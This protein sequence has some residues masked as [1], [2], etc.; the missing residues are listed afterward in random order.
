MVPSRTFRRS[1]EE[2]ASVLLWRPNAEMSTR[3]KKANREKEARA[4]APQRRTL[5]NTR[6]TAG[7]CLSFPEPPEAQLLLH[8]P[9]Q[10]RVDR[11]PALPP[12]AS[13][14]RGWWGPREPHKMGERQCPK[15]DNAGWTRAIIIQFY[16]MKQAKASERTD[17]GQIPGP[18]LSGRV[19][20]SKP[21]EP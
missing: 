11:P 3:R 20:L 6:V 8:P 4:R 15:A 5:Q 7:P 1:C 21:L 13:S 12:G 17:A 16:I 19:A 2:T 9:V 18:P 10:Y 14:L